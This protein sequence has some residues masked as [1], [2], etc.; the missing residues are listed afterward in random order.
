M[1]KECKKCDNLPVVSCL[2]L[3]SAATSWHYT[4]LILFLAL[5]LTLKAILLLP[6][7]FHCCPRKV[8]SLNTKVVGSAQR[9]M[10]IAGQYTV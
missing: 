7:R 2:F 1:K 10:F 3:V 5:S 8:T 4:H 9:V 6:G